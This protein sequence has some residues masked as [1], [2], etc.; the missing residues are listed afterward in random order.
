MKHGFLLDSLL[1]QASRPES[2]EV[3]LRTFRF[4]QYRGLQLAPREVPKLAGQ[5]LSLD[6]MLA[7]G[8]V[9]FGQR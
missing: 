4:L 1:I 7:G 9:E 2:R 3:P 5:L 8:P 6:G